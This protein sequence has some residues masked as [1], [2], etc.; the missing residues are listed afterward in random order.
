MSSEVLRLA[1]TTPLAL[2][3]VEQKQPRI[4]QPKAWAAHSRNVLWQAK[5]VWLSRARSKCIY[6]SRSKA[7][8][9]TQPTMFRVGHCSAHTSCICIA[10]LVF[11]FAAFKNTKD[12]RVGKEGV[13][14]SNTW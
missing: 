9:H 4:W 14:K 10:I 8:K 7:Q 12:R 5:T 11:A 13:S 3:L 2:L 1:A 6:C